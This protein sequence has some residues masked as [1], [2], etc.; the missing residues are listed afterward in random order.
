MT[1][2]TGMRIFIGVNKIKKR[3]TYHILMKMIGEDDDLTSAIVDRN[4]CNEARDIQYNMPDL[5]VADG[6]DVE[7]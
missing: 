4:A 1:I 6:C 3:K 5:F 7:I 2:T